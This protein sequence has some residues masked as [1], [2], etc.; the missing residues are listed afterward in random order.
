MAEPLKRFF[1]ETLVTRIA[2][3]LQ[4]AWSPFDR[5]AFVRQGAK[6]LDDMELKA[7]A[8]HIA[9]AM[10]THL[11]SSFPDA[12]AVVMSSL[13]PKHT[14]DELEGAGMGPFF[15][16]PHTMFGRRRVRPS[17]SSS[18]TRYGFGSPFAARPAR[19][20]IC[21]WTS[22]C[23]SSRCGARARRSSSCVICSWRPVRR[24][25][26]KSSSLWPATPP[27]R[28]NPVVTRWPCSSTAPA[29]RPATS[30]LSAK[31]VTPPYPLRPAQPRVKV[32]GGLSPLR[33]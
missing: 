25:I 24:S 23:A 8:A 21:T 7:R 22:R 4:A 12:A 19:C 14:S 27:E 16:M 1:D 5:A 17:A 18:A 13:G 6:G 32:E 33:A 26:L 3:R 31:G 30:M 15:Y 10:A 2:E 28:L 9:Q 20:R 11:P 29:W